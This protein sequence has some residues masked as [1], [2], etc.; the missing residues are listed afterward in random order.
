MARSAEPS[1]RKCQS[2]NLYYKEKLGGSSPVHIMGSYYCGSRGL[3][4]S[5]GRRAVD[6]HTRSLNRSSREGGILGILGR[7]GGRVS[8]QVARSPRNRLSDQMEA[9]FKNEVCSF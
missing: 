4:P 8:M 1:T 2:I 5:L 9:D 3:T 6:E 7:W